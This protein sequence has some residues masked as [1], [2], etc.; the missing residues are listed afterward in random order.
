MRTSSPAAPVP[1]GTADWS[2]GG[3]KSAARLVFRG[4]LP[5]LQG[6]PSVLT[7]K[8]ASRRRRTANLTLSGDG[9]ADSLDDQVVFGELSGIVLAVNQLAV[10]PHV[11]DT[12]SAFNQAGFASALF[13]DG[14]RQTG[15][16]GFVV[17]LHA[18]LDRNLGH[19]GFTSPCT[20]NAC[21]PV[22]H[23]TCSLD[24]MVTELTEVDK[25]WAPTGRRARIGGESTP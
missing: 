14:V 19:P 5:G 16:F 15:G 13:L 2:L 1:M 6:Q 18:V 8:I 17:S 21:G 4:M 7:G 22:S 9:L 24:G 3:L 25:S 10:H 23:T 12:A 20:P 11:E